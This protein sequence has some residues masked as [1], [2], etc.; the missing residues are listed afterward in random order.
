MK[1][2]SC[3]ICGVVLDLEQIEQPED[4]YDKEGV[5]IDSLTIWENRDFYPAFNCPVCKNKISFR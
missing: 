5:I 1:L 4:I 3:D 2:K